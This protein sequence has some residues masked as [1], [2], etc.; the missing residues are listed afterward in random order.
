MVSL[1]II[2]CSEERTIIEGSYVDVEI[3][4]IIDCSS[5][6]VVSD[7]SDIYDMRYTIE[8]WSGDLS[9]VIYQAEEVVEDNIYSLTHSFRAVAGDYRLVIFANYVDGTTGHYTTSNGL[10]DITI[11]DADYDANDPSRD[12]FGY[13][14]D[15]T[16]DSSFSLSGITLT[17]PMAMMT[18]AD[19]V[20]TNVT[21]GE[22]V[23]ISYGTSIPCGY[24]LL[25]E[26]VITGTTISPSYSTTMAGETIAY[27]YIFVSEP[28]SYS[29][30]FE[31]GSKEVSA[32]INFEQ[33]KTTNITATFFET[34]TN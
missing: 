24:D 22:S 34:Q 1:S 30:T 29:M 33:N 32:T 28:T 4:T 17:R 8:L 11:I 27:D 2:S 9:E 13:S 10:N 7:V 3:S 16:I 5:R 23:S 15:I 12:C 21:V 14:E 20:P 26:A 31:V 6:A 19:I 25:N 18:L